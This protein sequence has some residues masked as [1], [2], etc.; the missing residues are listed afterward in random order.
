MWCLRRPV[1]DYQIIDYAHSM[2]RWSYIAPGEIAVFDNLLLGG[3]I[4]DV[5]NSPNRAAGSAALGPSFTKTSER[6][7][8]G[9]FTTSRSSSP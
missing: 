3:M 2:A 5:P 1:L 6:L 7:F 9:I 8:A 4:Q